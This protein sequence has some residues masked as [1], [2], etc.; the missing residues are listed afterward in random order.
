MRSSLLCRQ[1]GKEGRGRNCFHLILYNKEKVDPEDMSKMYNN[2]QIEMV[3]TWR[4]QDVSETHQ[5][6]GTKNDCKPAPRRGGGLH[7]ARGGDDQCN[8]KNAILKGTEWEMQ[9]NS[10]IFTISRRSPTIPDQGEGRERRYQEENG[11]SSLQT[12]LQ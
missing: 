5:H 4:G 1:P 3:A 8:S 7:R 12:H 2:S 11:L 10:K 6:H 9:Q